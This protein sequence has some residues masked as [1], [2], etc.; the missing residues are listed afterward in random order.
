MEKYIQLM[1][2]KAR[3]R[4][5]TFNWETTTYVNMEYFVKFILKARILEHKRRVQESLLILTSSGAKRVGSSIGDEEGVTEFIEEHAERG[6]VIRLGEGRGTRAEAGVC[7]AVLDSSL[8]L[9]RG[10][11]KGDSDSIDLLYMSLGLFRFWCRC[12]LDHN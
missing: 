1:A 4:D 12:D 10:Y 2:D 9:D 11:V 8:T 5:Q 3:G 7:R 6:V